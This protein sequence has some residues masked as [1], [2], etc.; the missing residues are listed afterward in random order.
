MW[1]PRP[2]RC[3]LLK[4]GLQAT[5]RNIRGLLHWMLLKGEIA[6]RERKAG[7]GGKKQGEKGN[8]QMLPPFSPV[9]APRALRGAAWLLPW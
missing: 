2:R 4:L 3:L 8:S 9:L 1:G 7:E 5:S 6:G